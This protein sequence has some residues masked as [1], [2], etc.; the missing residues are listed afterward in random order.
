M[1]STLISTPNSSPIAPST[2]LAA[3]LDD[4]RP[5]RPAS[6]LLGRHGLFWL[7]STVFHTI[8]FF[9]SDTPWVG[10]VSWRK[11]I[12]FSISFALVFWAF[13]WVL[14]RLPDRPKMAGRLAKTFAWSSAF[15]MVLIIGQVWRGRPSHFA[16]SGADGVVFSLMGATVV[17]ISVCIIVLFVWSIRRARTS[18]VERLVIIAGIAM[19]I[20]GLGVGQWLVELGN[21]YVTRNGIVPE[22][23]IAGEAGVAKFPH[24]VAFHGI[25]VFM[26]AAALLR[27]VGASVRRATTTMAVIVTAY[28]GVLV[29]SITQAYGGRA[30]LN[31]EMVSGGLLIASVLTIVASF[32]SM[33]AKRVPSSSNPAPT[34]T[35]FQ[36]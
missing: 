9:I 4:L 27:Q 16:D 23:V 29:F 26:I 18:N 22:T 19:I 24:A 5:Q 34:G 12:V 6:R 32:A 14:D 2:S 28:A 30:P 10:S 3:V 33:F 21:D 8:V 7:A 31:L 35:T 20:T 17:V 36:A 1:T 11:P 15:E 25:Q 13:G